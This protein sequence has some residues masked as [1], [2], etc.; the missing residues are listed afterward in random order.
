[1]KRCAEWKYCLMASAVLICLLLVLALLTVEP[2]ATEPPPTEDL[3]SGEDNPEGIDLLP[4][5]EVDSG[6]TVRVLRG[7]TVTEMTMSEYLQ[8]VVRAE[9][10]ASFE[11]EALCA[12]TVAARTYTLYKMNQGSH[13]GAADICTNAACC[14]AWQDRDTAMAAWGADGERNEAKIANAVAATDGQALVYGG[15]PILA[16]FHAA[17]AGQT[18]GAGAVWSGDLPYL[19]SVSSPE[20]DGAVPNYY[21]RVEIPN[22]QF[23]KTFLAAHPEADFSGDPKGWIGEAA[24]AEDGVRVDT[25]TVGGVTVRGVEIRQLYGLRSTA[26]ETE[27]ED[28]KVVFYVT[29]YGHGVGMSQYGADYLARQGYTYQEILAHYYTDVT[30]G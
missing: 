14:Q 20:D 22:H 30:I 5:G 2:A 23:R 8:G 12:Q 10:P 18:S 25:I 27:A 15:A 9:M 28:G 29:G 24:L 21:S 26:F 3:L 17:S 7:D 6:Y 4:S 16:V 11:Q 13:A 19:Q 1:M